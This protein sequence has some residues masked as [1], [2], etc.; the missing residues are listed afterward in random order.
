M[1]NVTV[2]CIIQLQ[3]REHVNGAVRHLL[4]V[5]GS[6]GSGVY[7]LLPEHNQRVDNTSCYCQTNRHPIIGDNE[8]GQSPFP[9]KGSKVK[10]KTC[11]V[12]QC[13]VVQLLVELL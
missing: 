6:L 3:V 8:Q 4:W 1:K 10:H 7:G 13:V 2:Y 11:Q 9:Q 12:L 5:G